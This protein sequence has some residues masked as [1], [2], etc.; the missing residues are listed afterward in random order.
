MAS[1]ACSRKCA[2]PK[3]LLIGLLQ[4]RSCRCASNA[5]QPRI[6]SEKVASK[7]P[8]YHG[9]AISR[10]AAVQSSR[11]DTLPA[12]SALW[13]S[14][15]ETGSHRRRPA[16]PEGACRCLAGSRGPSRQ[17]SRSAGSLPAQAALPGD[18][19]R[20]CAPSR[21]RHACLDA[22]RFPAPPCSSQ[23]SR[24]P[25]Q[26]C[27]HGGQARASRT[28]PSWSGRCCRGR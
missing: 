12:G 3:H 26:A 28:R 7:S 15:G 9:S 17:D 19:R 11:S 18:A 5:V 1:E 13:A 4:F 2:C 22:S 16:P 27:L 25:R 8:V 21:G 20:G 23:P 24:P 14:S 6:T 10:G